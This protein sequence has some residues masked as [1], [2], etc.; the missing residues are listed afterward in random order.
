MKSS[1]SALLRL[2]L[3]LPPQRTENLQIFINSY[4]YRPIFFFQKNLVFKNPAICFSKT[5]V[6]CF[7]AGSKL[8]HSL[9]FLFLQYFDLFAWILICNPNK[10]GSESEIPS[11]GKNLPVNRLVSELNFFD[12]ESHS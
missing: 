1:D 7:F 11:L 5:R 2:F 9:S 3:R 6:L 10:C 8:Q 12:I 4:R